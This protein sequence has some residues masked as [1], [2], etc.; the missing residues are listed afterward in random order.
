MRYTLTVLMLA[1]IALAVSPSDPCGTGFAP[2]Q[3]NDPR[4]NALR[5]Q[6]RAAIAAGNDALVRDIEMQ[7]QAIYTEGQA[8]LPS[9]AVQSSPFG[10]VPPAVEPGDAPD[11]TIATNPAGYSAIAADYEMDGTMWVAAAS[12]SDSVC[13][14]YKSVD[15]GQTW[16][17]FRDFWFT[18]KA[19]MRKLQ[20]VV[21]QGDSAKVY[22]FALT[23]R[24]GSGDLYCIRYSMDGTEF[25]G[26]SVLVG[27]DTITDFAACRDYSTYAYWLYAVAHNGLRAVTSPPS[28]ICRSTAF[29]T[30]WAQA[31][32]TYN[33][34]RP[35]LSGGAGT[36]VY[37]A[38]VPNQNNWRGWVVTGLSYNWGAN[39]TWRFHDQRPDTG[40]VY[41]CAVA[42]AFT[43]PGTDAVFWVGYS[44]RTL[45]SPTHYEILA[46]ASTDTGHTFLGPTVVY[47]NEAGYIDMKS[48]Y[49]VG[50]T[51]MNI[52]YNGMGTVYRQY[53]NAPTP[54]AWSDTLRINQTYSSPIGIGTGP[55]LAYSPPSGPGGGAVFLSDDSTRLLWN[56]PWMSGVAERPGSSA[57]RGL[58][59]LPNPASA[60]HPV[61]LA[62][63]GLG[64]A[65]AR[66][67]L[68]DALGREVLSREVD[69]RH[70]SFDV[71]ALAA[72]V[73]FV[74]LV[75]DR[76]EQT[77]QLILR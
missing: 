48:Y 24:T 37:L 43:S 19:L 10:V 27:A 26:Y 68:F 44:H 75:T 11:V 46:L 73:Y 64:D 16:Q 60:G 7:L 13:R 34:D 36:F 1:A 55:Q 66:L 72:G 35:H 29:G 56:A 32:T 18:T 54:T 14:V 59:I 5:A 15:H 63:Q 25:A 22:V 6:E 42:P 38:A 23:D 47:P 9:P 17:Y 31:D 28:I 74:R 12:A 57:A 51:Y 21:G 58:S 76:G 50:N 67:Q 30:N 3:S 33:A 70:S 20:L 2:D 53:A 39:G 45:S 49:A 40:L 71:P 41:D 52:V 69:I 77:G 8:G 62:A 4:V 65:P 61:R